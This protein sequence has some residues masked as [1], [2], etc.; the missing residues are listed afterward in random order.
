MIDGNTDSVITTIS[1][2]IGDEPFGVSANSATNKIY[3]ANFADDTVSVID[4]NTDSVI[5]TISTGIGDEPFGV[6]SEF[7]YKQDLRCKLC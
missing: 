4:G 5:T 7:S 6:F 2:G 3:V 1:T